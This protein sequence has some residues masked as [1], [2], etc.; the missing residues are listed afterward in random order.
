M[1]EETPLDLGHGLTGI[2]TRPHEPTQRPLWILLNAGFVH[3]AGPF[4]MHVDLAREL[5]AQGFPV[6]RVDQPGVGDAPPKRGGD[7]AVIAHGFDRLAASIGAD[8]F[9]IGGLCSA[10]DQ[11]WKIALADPRVCGLL[12]LDPFAKRGLWFRVGQLKLLLGRGAA[13]AKTLLGRLMRRKRTVVIADGDMRDWPPPDKARDDLARM[14][15]RD[16][17]VFA[18]YTGGAAKYFTHRAQIGASFG[19][20]ATHPAMHFEYWPECDHMFMR[21]QDRRRLVQAIC[22]WGGRAFGG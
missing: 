22:A 15:A 3:R 19:A 6:L 4:R 20:T 21:Q 9:V 13:A 1:I 10:A 12:L 18:L 5:A 17:R 11:G 14:A 2:L 7:I 8:R 16:V